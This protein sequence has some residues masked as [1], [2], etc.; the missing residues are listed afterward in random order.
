[1][2]PILAQR[3]MNLDRCADDEFRPFLEIEHVFV[4]VLFD[5][6]LPKRSDVRENWSRSSSKGSALC[7]WDS[8]DRTTEI[9]MARATTETRRI[10]AKSR[11]RRVGRIRVPR[12]MAQF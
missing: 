1:M 4:P 3:A 2:L 5:S 9:P 7:A 10:A 12:T 8:D 11:R 6:C